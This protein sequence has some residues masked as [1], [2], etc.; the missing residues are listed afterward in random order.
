[1]LRLVRFSV[2][3]TLL[4]LF[5]ALFW[6][7][8]SRKAVFNGSGV[9]D[10]FYDVRRPIISGVVNQ[11]GTTQDKNQTSEAASNGTR[12]RT[13]STLH[14]LGERHSGTNW[15]AG[16]LEE[17]FGHALFVHR[18]LSRWK[19]WFQT[20]GAYATRSAVV[21]VMVR[22]VLPWVEAMRSNPYHAPHH[23]NLSWRDFVTRPWTMDV[24]E[25]SNHADLCYNHFRV[26]EVVPCRETRV[27]LDSGRN[28]TPV[29]ELRPL[30]RNRA[31]SSAEGSPYDSVVDLR[32]DKVR[33]FLAVRDFVGVG[34]YRL[35]RYEDAVLRGTRPV[36]E[37]L[38]SALGIEATC[39]PTEPQQHLKTQRPVPEEYLTWM[40]DRVDWETEAMV[41][42]RVPATSS[43]DLA[44]W[45]FQ[46]QGGHYLL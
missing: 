14:L 12:V 30:G 10:E 24:D 17:C 21:V 15:M 33:N 18:G 36:V 43:D 19:H 26:G 42:Y 46:Q 37:W 22:H 3:G 29:Y 39:R 34:H 6:R 25:E 28:V 1:M 16:H 31:K 35:V 27:R 41:G 44:S 38:Q 2:R 23:F 11:Q 4:L 9:V 13:H 5:V 7:T 40:R 8:T 32:R 45:G 20:D